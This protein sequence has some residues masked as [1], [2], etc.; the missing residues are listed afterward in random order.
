MFL[1]TVLLWATAK[2]NETYIYFYLVCFINIIQRFCICV[3]SAGPGAIAPFAPPFRR[4]WRPV[5]RFRCR[6]CVRPWKTNNSGDRTGKRHNVVVLSGL[7][8]KTAVFR[9]AVLTAT[10]F[11]IRRK[12]SLVL[13]VSGLVVV[14]HQQF[15]HVYVAFS[16][17]R[18]TIT[19]SWPPS[20]VEEN[21]L[22]L[23]PQL[24]V[25]YRIITLEFYINVSSVKFNLTTK[26]AYRAGG[27]IVLIRIG[28]PIEWPYRYNG[29]DR[30]AENVE[31]RH[32]VTGSRRTPPSLRRTV[33]V[34]AKPGRPLRETREWKQIRVVDS[35]LKRKR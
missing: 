14:E 26:D 34:R 32:V 27:G 20:L 22:C 18:S 24:T 31:C 3:I 30:N 2:W 28:N 9:S 23:R 8:P 13:R 33:F 10:V 15:V 4:C 25:Q 19:T 5:P 6:R 12:H 1:P 16:A 35:S 7:F 17:I 21:I 11:T 29:S